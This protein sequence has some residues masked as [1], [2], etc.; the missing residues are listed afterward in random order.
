MEI[1]FLDQK[2]EMEKY[3]NFDLKSF[4]E[5]MDKLVNTE[6]SRIPEGI[7]KVNLEFS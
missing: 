6:D 5:E 3:K 4:I 7:T 1:R 2:I